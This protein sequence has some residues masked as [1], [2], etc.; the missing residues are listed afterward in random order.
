MNK[1]ILIVEDDNDIRETLQQALELEGFRVFTAPNGQDALES[2]PKIEKPGLI[3]LDLMMPVMN[4]WQFLEAKKGHAD[5]M[6]IPVIVITA[7]GDK[8]KTVDANGVIKKPVDL[9]DLLSVV[10]QYCE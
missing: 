1:P 7:A 9:D 4:G 3:L 8:V 6:T 10:K 2:L 5:L